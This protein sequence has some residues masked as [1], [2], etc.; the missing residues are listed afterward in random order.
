M[1][2]WIEIGGKQHRVWEGDKIEIPLKA[3]VGDE[4][5]I[6]PIGFY[7]G[8]NLITEKEKLEKILVKCNVI[9]K[10]K[11][12]KIYSFKK[13]AKTGYKRKIGY[14]DTLCVVEIKEIIDKNKEK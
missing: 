8:K 13:K 5:E 4:L 7:D 14:R 1:Y 9:E 10:K 2:V 12:E 11:G 6:T 3:K